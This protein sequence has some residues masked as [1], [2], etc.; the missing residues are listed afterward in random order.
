MPTLIVG[1]LVFGVIAAAV[2]KIVK[3]RRSGKS[4]GCGCGCE[5]CGACGPASQDKR[6]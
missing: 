5:G 1:I 2:R 6:T 3:D 4:C